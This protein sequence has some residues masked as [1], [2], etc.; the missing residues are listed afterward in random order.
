MSKGTII[1]EIIKVDGVNPKA[2]E[3]FKTAGGLK[4]GEK[5][6]NV[7]MGIDMGVFE[8][9]GSYEVEISVND[10]GYK[11]ITKVLNLGLDEKVET[12]AAEKPQTTKPSPD[13]FASRDLSMES[14]GLVQASAISVAS[15]YP[16]LTVKEYL[17]KVE[18]VAKG[19]LGV[20]ESVAKFIKEKRS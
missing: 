16:G 10:K 9:D 14:S 20:K 7:A 18:E 17:Q 5:W 13:V 4:V 6:I 11:T 8:R 2:S 1:K 3:K 19:L 15:A 12:K